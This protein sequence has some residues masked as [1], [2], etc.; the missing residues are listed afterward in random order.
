MAA[1]LTFIDVLEEGPHAE[2]L[3]H[4]LRTR[5]SGRASVGRSTMP[6]IHVIFFDDPPVEEQ[7]AA[8]VSALN[9]VDELEDRQLGEWERHLAV[10]GP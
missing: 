9:A 4:E 5:L 7:H 10:R 1:V 6:P 3:L 8:V 2:H